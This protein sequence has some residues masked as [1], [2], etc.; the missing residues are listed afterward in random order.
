M[1]NSRKILAVVLVLVFMFTVAMSSAVFAGTENEKGNGKGTATEKVKGNEKNE[2]KGTEA[3]ADADET[4]ADAEETGEEKAVKEKDKVMEQ[5]KLLMKQMIEARK[6]GDTASEAE[7]LAQVIAF[8][9]Q[10][11]LMTRNQYSE[12]EMLQIQQEAQNMLAA[13]PSL[14][15]LPVEKIVAKGK[16][17]KLGLPPVVKDGRVLVPIRAFSQAYGAEVDWLSDTH[18]ITILKDGVLMVINL[19]NNTATIGDQVINLEMPVK[20]INGRTVMPVDFLAEQLGLKVEI[21][22][23]DNDVEIEEVEEVEEE[24]TDTTSEE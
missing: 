19:E 16:F 6:S 3:E 14:E 11:R 8:K 9:E 21:D 15:V 17:L 12:E 18:E 20:N 1:K 7:L 10:L 13:D 24:I 4:E 23:D 2:L 22:E 5:K